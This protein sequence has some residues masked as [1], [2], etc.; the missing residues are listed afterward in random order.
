VQRK[1]AE[2]WIRKKHS[3]SAAS[4]ALTKRARHEKIRLGYFSAD[5]CNHAVSSLI[6]ELIENHDRSTFEVIAF[7]FGP[8][9]KDET[10]TRSEDTFDKFIDVRNYSDQYTAILSRKMA[11][12][13]AIDLGGFTAYARTGIFALRASP[14]QV[15][16]LGY[17]G[18]MGADYIDYIVADPIVIP[19]DS[20]HHYCEKIAYLPN[21]YQVNAKHFVSDKAF[22]RTELGLPPTGFV[23]CCFNANYKI[24]PR[25][26]DCWMRILKNVEVNALWLVEDNVTVRIDWF[27]QRGCH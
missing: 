9:Q 25:V 7:S 11:I 4:P 1:A 19:E 12:D 5:F 23:F 20:K 18:T 16:Y 2:I 27:S 13:I 17:P 3:T 15:H 8:D 14:I 10:R 26:F 24:T 21:S 22:T 6:A